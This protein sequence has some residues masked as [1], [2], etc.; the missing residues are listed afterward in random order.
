[1]R[2]HLI[3]ASD[4]LS[5]AQRQVDFLSTLCTFGGTDDSVEL[6]APAIS[7]LY[8]VIRD[9]AQRIQKAGELIKEHRDSDRR[10]IG[11]GD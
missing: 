10:I 1:M 6:D 7:G 3:E 2:N 4:V 5:E 8:Y 9:I 11:G